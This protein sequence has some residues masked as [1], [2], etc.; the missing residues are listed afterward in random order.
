MCPNPAAEVDACISGCRSIAVVGFVDC[1][2]HF[3]TGQD[4]M[5]RGAV[6]R[7][8]R[9]RVRR[10]RGLFRVVKNQNE[11]RALDSHIQ[12]PRFSDY[13]HCIMTITSVHQMELDK[14]P[15]ALRLLVE[16]ELASGNAIIEVGHS[17]PAPPAGAYI[18]LANK[19]STRARATD[20]ELNY[21]E[22]NSSIYSGEF[23]DAQ[24]IYFVIE[25]PNP[26]PLEL[27]MEAIRKS[28]EPQPYSPTTAANPPRANEGSSKRY[29]ELCEEALNAESQL[30]SVAAIQQAIIAAVKAGASFSNSHKEGGTNIFWKSGR[31][32]RSDYGDY[33]DEQQ[34]T[35]EIE[36]L[37]MLHQF[38]HW[39]ATRHSGKDQLSEIDTWRLILRQ[40]NLLRRV[41]L[42]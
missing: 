3:Q 36:F 12:Y 4:H 19:V 29:R 35:D 10:S 27:D 20:D 38:C 31:F 6:S 41:G 1:F 42:R 11:P 34:F 26:P 21:Y 39:D 28:Y 5:W 9:D 2:A 7:C 37:K 14:F 24:R 8:L 23:A 17:F 16:T 30:D 25:P 40:M 15:L 22:R 13:T 33:P 18:K 32:V